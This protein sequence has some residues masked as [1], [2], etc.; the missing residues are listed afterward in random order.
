MY[1]TLLL[2]YEYLR[3]SGKRGFTYRKLRAYWSMKRI[4][5]NHNDPAKEWHTVERAVRKLAELGYLERKMLRLGRK[6]ITVFFP[7][8]LFESF[9]YNYKQKYEKAITK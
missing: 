9:I 6:K 1:R 5:N 2:I 7:T 8:P 4:Y 3:V